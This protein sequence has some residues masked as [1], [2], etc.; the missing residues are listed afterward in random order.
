MVKPE[1]AEAMITN[2][3]AGFNQPYGIGWALT[4]TRFRTWRIDRHTLL[5][6]STKESQLRPAYD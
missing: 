4:G 3:N 1:T 2:Q 6:R 5:A